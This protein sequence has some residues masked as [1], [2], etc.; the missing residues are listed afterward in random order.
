MIHAEGG[1]ERWRTVPELAGEL[2][3]PELAIR[4]L[5]D[6]GRLEAVLFGDDWR[7]SA[8]AVRSYVRRYSS[9]RPSPRV[10]ALRWAAAGLVSIATLALSTVLLRAQ[11]AGNGAATSL[12][13]HGYLELAGTPVE[14]KRHVTFT[15]YDGNGAPTA[16]SEAQTVTV[17]GGHFSVLLG[18]QTSFDGVLR[19][20]VA[21][22]SLGLT[23]QDVGMD[24]MPTG[25]PVALAGRQLLASVPYARRGAP[26]RDFVVDGSLSAGATTVAS[27]TTPSVAVT[28]SATAASATVTGAL[29]AGSLATSG[30]ISSGAITAAGPIVGPGGRADCGIPYFEFSDCRGAYVTAPITACSFRICNACGC[31]R[32]NPAGAQ[33]GQMLMQTPGY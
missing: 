16:W 9:V 32:W 2:Q 15:L 21:P 3:L 31:D 19:T 18:M 22:L 12:P 8:A 30:T 28:G 33:A 10:R 1:P 7:V 29:A 13:Y 20:T 5:I 24:G 14:G 6:T 23:V 25:T 11:S 4:Q 27:L 17:A 26:G